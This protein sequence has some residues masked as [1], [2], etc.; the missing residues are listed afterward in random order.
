MIYILWLFTAVKTLIAGILPLAYQAMT[1]DHSSLLRSTD[2]HIFI[3][4]NSFSFP[5]GLLCTSD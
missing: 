5:P 3:A 4:A 1:L 2:N